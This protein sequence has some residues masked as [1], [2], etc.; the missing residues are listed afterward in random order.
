MSN[1]VLIFKGKKIEDNSQKVSL[2][3]RSIIH[4]VDVSK[5]LLPEIRVVFKVQQNPEESIKVKVPPHTVIRDVLQRQIK[6]ILNK[7]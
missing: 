6:P 1:F 7:G 4:M 3:N 5:T 2:Q